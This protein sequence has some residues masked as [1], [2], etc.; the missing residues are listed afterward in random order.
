MA[1]AAEVWDR[2]QDSQP[3]STPPAGEKAGPK[4]GFQRGHD[5]RRNVT[6]PGPGRP[7]EK[8]REEMRKLVGNPKVKQAF[9]AILED[10]EHRHFPK[11]LSLAVEQAFGKAPQPVTGEDGTGPVEIAVTHEVIDPGQS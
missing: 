6:K 1:D 8:F 10:P 11:V 9:K 3:E 2:Q 5:P 7:A 4:G